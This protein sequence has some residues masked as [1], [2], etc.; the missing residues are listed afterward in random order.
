MILYVSS[1]NVYSSTY[2]LIYLFNKSLSSIYQ[3]PDTMSGAEIIVADKTY[4]VLAL[5]Q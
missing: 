1:K 2:S 3:V 5:M 4:N